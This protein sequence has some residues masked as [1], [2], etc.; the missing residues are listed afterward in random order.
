MSTT[1]TPLELDVLIH[2]YVSPAPHPRQDAE[3]VMA[4]CARLYL[5]E[6]IEPSDHG[7]WQTTD[8][9]RAWLAAILRTPMPRQAWVDATGNVIEVES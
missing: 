1:L 8:K 2:C 7:G 4:A 5:D 6:V 9:G 3:S